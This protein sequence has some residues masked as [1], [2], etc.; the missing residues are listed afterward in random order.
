[1]IPPVYLANRKPTLARP[2]FNPKEKA[3]QSQ[4]KTQLISALKNKDFRFA[5]SP[6]ESRHSGKAKPQAFSD[7]VIDDGY[8][9]QRMGYEFP[10][11]CIPEFVMAGPWAKHRVKVVQSCPPTWARVNQHGDKVYKRR[12]CSF[13]DSAAHSR[14][15]DNYAGIEISNLYASKMLIKDYFKELAKLAP[16][17]K[18]AALDK[19][20]QASLMR[21]NILWEPKQRLSSLA[22][23]EEKS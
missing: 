15:P 10:D 12:A 7:Y 13:G 20:Y 23:P 3:M 17:A 8:N 9:Q 11:F 16:N 2:D 14:Q 1:L 4:I 21:L 22:R 19:K 6:K 5:P 18:A